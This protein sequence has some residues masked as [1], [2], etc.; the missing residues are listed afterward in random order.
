L[1]FTRVNSDPDE[2]DGLLGVIDKVGLNYKEKRYFGWEIEANDA[3]L[4]LMKVG[5]RSTCSVYG[6][7]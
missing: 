5:Y 4:L 3:K 6:H 2:T 1:Q 7:G